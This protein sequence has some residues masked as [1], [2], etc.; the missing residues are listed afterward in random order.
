MAIKLAVF[1]SGGGAVEGGFAARKA[2]G[3]GWPGLH[4]AAA[5]T[6]KKRPAP[7]AGK[8]SNDTP[9]DYRPTTPSRADCTLYRA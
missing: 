4:Y 8:P 7:E 5:L 6:S 3:G 1:P 2:K 9:A